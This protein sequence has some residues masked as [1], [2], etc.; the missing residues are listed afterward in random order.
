MADPLVTIICPTFNRGALLHCA[1]QSVLRQ[2]FTD[3]EMRVMGD[4]C[5]DDSEKIVAGFNDARL[6]WYNFPKNSGNQSG[7][8]N[9]GVRRARGKFIAFIGHDDL[10]FPWHLARLVKHINETGADLVHDF[11]ASVG[12]D[13]IEG[14]Y[15]APHPR[16]GYERIYFP[17]SSWLHRREL[18]AHIGHWRQP[19]ELAW[20]IDYDFSRRAALAGKRISFLPSLGVLKFHS[21]VWKFYA[22]TGPPPQEKWLGALQKNPAALN[23]EV[24]L[25]FAALSAHY[26]QDQDKTPFGLAWEETK[27]SV[28][29]AARALVREIIF[30]YGHDRWPVQA[31]LRRRMKRL[32]ARQRITRGL[33]NAP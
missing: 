5:T 22:H 9:E 19:D 29:N 26:F 4:G 13:G 30:N 7:P 2:D 6:H 27:K 32:R 18:A 10:W 8:N 31:V 25:Q 11:A 3:F 17:T 33:T 16:S 20:A 1:L 15:G 24:L 23:E 12:R 21:Q 14:F 28:K